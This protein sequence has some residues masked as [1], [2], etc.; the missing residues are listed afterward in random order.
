MTISSHAAK[1]FGLT[2]GPDARSLDAGTPV[3]QRILPLPLNSDR[4]PRQ[5]RSTP[6]AIS[7]SRSRAKTMG[8]ASPAGSAV[9]QG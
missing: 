7:V 1:W 2:K 6:P 8:R 5:A 3:T 4:S 9:R